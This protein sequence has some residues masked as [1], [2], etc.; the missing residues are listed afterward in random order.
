MMILCQETKLAEGACFAGFV[1]M[2]TGMRHGRFAVSIDEREI[3]GNPLLDAWAGLVGGAL[4]VTHALRQVLL[5]G[6]LRA[7]IAMLVCRR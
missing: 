4:P 5:H 1:G 2:L 6:A 7:L 3:G